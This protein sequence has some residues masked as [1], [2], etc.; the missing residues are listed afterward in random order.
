MTIYKS[1]FLN[2][3]IAALMLASALALSSWVGLMIVYI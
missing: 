1:T 3:L 2:R